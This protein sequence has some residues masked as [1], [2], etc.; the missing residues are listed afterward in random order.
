[1]SY[2]TPSKGACPPRSPGAI[3]GVL[4]PRE[5]RGRRPLA[6]A[7]ERWGAICVAALLALT[8]CF[9]APTYQ[10]PP[11]DHFDGEVFRNR[12]ESP[13]GFT[14]FLKWQSTRRPVVWPAWRE[15][16][17]GPPPPRRVDGDALRVTFV[18]HA[19]VLIQTAGLNIIT[20]PVW[21]HR[22]S[23]VS[24]IGPA[25]IRV[26]GIRFDDLPPIDAILISHNHYDHLDVPTLRRLVERDTPRIFA[27][28]GTGAL[29]DQEGL[30]GWTDLD[31]WQSAQLSER[32]SVV[33]TPGQHFSGRGL[34]DGSGVLWAGF[35][36]RT[37]GGAIYFAGD[38]GMGPHF[39]EIRQRFGAPRLA[40]LPIGAYTPRW[41][42]A[43][44]HV[45]PEQAVE[46]HRILGAR[47]SVA[48]HFGTFPLA[49]EGPDTPI[50]DLAMARSAQGVSSER[51]RVLDFGQGLDVPPR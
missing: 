9:S 20:D 27:G 2:S 32:V 11:S 6:A 46:A 28:L 3:H 4:A 21:S 39:G 17:P 43:P 1:M 33:A 8:G 5:W 38:T 35:V 41:F 48:I 23:P 24:W 47:L 45:S 29:F 14:R 13:R 40:I 30:G 18:N 34:S 42:M 16:T 7:V 36:L 44:V 15:A 51:F 19:T 22:V 25:R 50:R 31:W 37:P 12:V 49:D 10:G 26:P